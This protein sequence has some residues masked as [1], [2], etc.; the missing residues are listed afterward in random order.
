MRLRAQQS[1]TLKTP[2]LFTAETGEDTA[3]VIKCTS[4][5]VK[6][7]TSAST[8]KSLKFMNGLLVTGL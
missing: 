5:E 1:M 7:M 8:Y 6:V 2:R 4:G 3:N